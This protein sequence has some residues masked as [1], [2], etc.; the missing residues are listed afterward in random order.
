MMSA[1]VRNSFFV[2]MLAIICVLVFQL[3]A[4]AQ[5]TAPGA[6]APS[7]AA[8]KFTAS[9][10]KYAPNSAKVQ[11]GAP[12]NVTLT[13]GGTV[14]HTWVVLDKD[15]KTTLFKLQAAAG[16]SAS[17]AF[18]PPSAGSYAFICDIAGHREAGMTGTLSVQ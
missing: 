8:L 18:T 6:A 9:E 5:A 1:K 14:D 16:Q 10:F 15:G 2:V 11:R 3:V 12:V 7:A 17:G 13:N 4:K